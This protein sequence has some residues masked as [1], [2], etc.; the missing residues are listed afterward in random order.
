MTRRTV[1]ETSHYAFFQHP[2]SFLLSSLSILLSNLFSNTIS[3]SRILPKLRK[4]CRL[5][6]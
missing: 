1:R 4:N 2:D 6:V 3:V 5:R